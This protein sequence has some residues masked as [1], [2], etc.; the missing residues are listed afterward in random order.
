MITC[1]K[2]S[3]I[4]CFEGDCQLTEVCVD[5]NGVCTSAEEADFNQKRAAASEEDALYSELCEAFRFDG[6]I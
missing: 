5:Q 1:K 3:C 2:S 4:Y 6:S